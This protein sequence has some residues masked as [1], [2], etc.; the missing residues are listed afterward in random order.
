VCLRTL[1]ASTTYIYIELNYSEKRKVL[2]ISC[3]DSE[4]VLWVFDLWKTLAKL[5][6]N[7]DIAIKQQLAFP[8]LQS[9]ASLSIIWPKWPRFT[10]MIPLPLPAC[11]MDQ[12]HIPFGWNHLFSTLTVAP[13]MIQMV[14]SFI[15]LIIMTQ[16]VEDTLTFWICEAQFSV[17]YTR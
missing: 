11:H 8:P 6:I 1:S 5:V 14:S 15:A 17:P 2:N 16:R 12:N 10:L 4:K 7:W 9:W 3:D 13:C